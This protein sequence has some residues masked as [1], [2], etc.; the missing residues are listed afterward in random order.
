MPQNHNLPPTVFECLNDLQL[1]VLVVFFFLERS[2]FPLYPFKFFYFLWNV[3]G[4]FFS[5]KKDKR[6][7]KKEKEKNEVDLNP[8]FLN[9]SGF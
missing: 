3:L 8:S 5:I 7:N 2:P 4:S 1:A 9:A 6:R